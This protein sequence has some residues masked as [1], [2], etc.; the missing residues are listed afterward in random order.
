MSDS[1]PHNLDCVEH[2]DLWYAGDHILSV[3]WW[4]PGSGSRWRCLA[5]PVVMACRNT[6]GR[7]TSQAGLQL[8][9]R[10]ELQLCPKGVGLINSQNALCSAFQWSIELI[11]HLYLLMDNRGQGS[12]QAEEEVVEDIAASHDKLKITYV[13]MF[14]MK[15]KSSFR[16]I[17]F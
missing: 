5:D 17:I 12:D 7:W 9:P 4:P 10:A 16:E 2:K 6:M 11:A 13:N 15:K 8:V 14:W 1:K 3:K